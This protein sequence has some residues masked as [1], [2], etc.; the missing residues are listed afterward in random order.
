ML[1]PHGAFLTA[2]LSERLVPSWQLS[3][4]RPIVVGSELKGF[5]FRL[6]VLGI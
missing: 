5:S 6:R 2:Y 3:L 1:S 4:L